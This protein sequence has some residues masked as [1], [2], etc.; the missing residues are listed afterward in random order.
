MGSNQLLY[1]SHVSLF[2]AVFVSWQRSGFNSPFSVS[3][4]QL[5][6]YSRIASFATYHKCVKEEKLFKGKF[7]EARIPKVDL[8]TYV[9]LKKIGVNI[10][11]QTKQLN[12]ASQKIGKSF[13]G[14]LNYNIKKLYHPD[15]KKRAEL[16][17][18]PNLNRYVYHTSLNFSID[19]QLD[20]NKLVSIAHDYLKESGYTNNQFMIFRHHDAPHPHIHLLATT[21]KISGITYFH[22]GFKIKGQAL[23]N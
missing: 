9:E 14:A 6:S 1:A 4:R 22:N 3:R 20:N 2:T 19:D 5:M 7:P 12:A 10:N 21:G 23:G 17:L 18:K 8:D 15:Q 11:Q 13:L 16:S